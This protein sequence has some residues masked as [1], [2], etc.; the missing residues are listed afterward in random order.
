MDHRLVDFQ[1]K[2]KAVDISA[3][4]KSLIGAQGRE[5]EMAGAFRD[6]ESLAVPLKN[7]LGCLRTRSAADRSCAW[8]VGE[9]SY[10]PISFSWFG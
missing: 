9:T 1:M 6:V 7:F 4:T 5:S 8:S 3:V 10:Q 2:L